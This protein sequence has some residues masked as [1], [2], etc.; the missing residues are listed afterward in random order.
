MQRSFSSLQNA[1]KSFAKFTPVDVVRGLLKAGSEA[2][3]GVEEVSATAQFSDIENFTS[4][5]ESVPPQNLIAVMAEYFDAM[6]G[7][8]ETSGG[9]V[10]DLIGDAIFSFFNAPTVVGPRH[11]VICINAALSMQVERKR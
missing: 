8:I 3:P 1:L 9:T 10:G 11:A 6:T 7:I 5:S 4:I 2:Q